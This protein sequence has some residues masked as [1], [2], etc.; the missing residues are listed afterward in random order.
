[1]FEHLREKDIEC[2]YE[3]YGTKKE[4]K[5][6]HVFHLNIRTETA[7]KCN[8]EQCGFFRKYVFPAQ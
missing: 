6:A 5:I 7:R 1:M 4:R 2:V 8:N 3:I